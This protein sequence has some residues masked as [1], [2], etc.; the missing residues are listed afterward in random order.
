MQFI[1]DVMSQ[2]SSDKNRPEVVVVHKET[3]H[4]DELIRD[5]LLKRKRDVR[6]PPTPVKVSPH[7]THSWDVHDKVRVTIGRAFN[8][9]VDSSSNVSILSNYLS[10]H[11]DDDND[12]DDDED[13]DEDED[14][15]NR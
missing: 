12:E 13:E 5:P 9:N 7:A 1:R 2:G 14:E 3:M 4:V 11:E 15:D 8:V 6:P 10:T